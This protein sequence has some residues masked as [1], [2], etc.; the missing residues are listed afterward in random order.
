MTEAIIVACITAGATIAVQ[1]IISARTRNDNRKQ[2]DKTLAL[3]EHRIKSLESKQ[4]KHNGLIERMIK[5]EASI[6][7]AHHRID[8]LHHEHWEG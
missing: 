3:V 2:M 6:K 8:E 5:A 7:S 4:D 1:L